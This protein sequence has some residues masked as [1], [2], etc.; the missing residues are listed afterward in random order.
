[1]FFCAL[2][3]KNASQNCQSELSELSEQFIFKST[4]C[5]SPIL[6]NC[7]RVVW[8]HFYGFFAP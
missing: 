2:K 3:C 4:M 8:A 6:F 1:M 5:P 7:Y